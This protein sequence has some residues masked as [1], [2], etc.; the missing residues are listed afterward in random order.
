MSLN[1][2]SVKEI[3]EVDTNNVSPFL[4]FLSETWNCFLPPKKEMRSCGTQPRKWKYRR[5]PYFRGTKWE[6]FI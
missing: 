1:N 2:C 5:E 3:K 6:C 4:T